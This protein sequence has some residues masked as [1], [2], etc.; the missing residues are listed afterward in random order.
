MAIRTLTLEQESILKR[1][2]EKEAASKKTAVQQK[3]E[4]VAE[5]VEISVKPDIAEMATMSAEI[6]QDQLQAEQA[7]FEGSSF[8]SLKKRK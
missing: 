2:L 3:L 6:Q 8:K 1:S 4:L 7:D 5:K